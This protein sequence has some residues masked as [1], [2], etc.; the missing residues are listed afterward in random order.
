MINLYSILYFLNIFVSLFI[1]LVL[2]V[3]YKVIK[4]SAI[5]YLVPTFISL[6]ATYFLLNLKNF[7]IKLAFFI[8]VVVS[9][10]CI[11]SYYYFKKKKIRLS[12]LRALALTERQCFSRLSLLKNSISGIRRDIFLSKFL[13]I[14]SKRLEYSLNN[15]DYS[16]LKHVVCHD[17]SLEEILR[18]N[19]LLSFFISFSKTIFALYLMVTGIELFL[20]LIFIKFVLKRRIFLYFLL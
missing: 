13:S 10:V 19:F 9:F 18:K 14:Y 2:L 6:L 12:I 16:Y 11:D 7:K 8:V 5:S 17:I 15:R 1:F 3:R 20:F 4:I